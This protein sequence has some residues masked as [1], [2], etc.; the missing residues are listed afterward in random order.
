MTTFIK[1]NA[2]LQKALK[3]QIYRYMV[4]IKEKLPNYLEEF[5]MS[6]FYDLYTPSSSYNRQ[7]RIISAIMTSKIKDIG[8][9][10]EFEL[11]LDPTAVSYDPSFWTSHGVT[12]YKQGD[13][14]DDVFQN[15]ANGIHGSTEYGVTSGRFWEKFLNEIGESGIYDIFVG[16][17]K[18]MSDKC[19]LVIK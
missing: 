18:Y 7:Y 13:S 19:H 6:E 15:I 11:Y 12:Y 8:N 3:Q 17:K 9:G 16:F 4:D 1:N 14:A 5:I 10:Y 2:D